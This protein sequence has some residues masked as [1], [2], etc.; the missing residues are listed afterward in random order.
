MST[1]L[2]NPKDERSFEKKIQTKAINTQKNIYSA[3][4]NFE[5]FCKEKYD[6]SMDETIAEYQIVDIDI[7]YL[8]L[9]EWINWNS[10]KGIYPNSIPT[11]FSYLKK[12]FRHFKIKIT[13]EDIAE[14]LSFP[15]IIDEEKHPLT[16]DEIKKIFNVSN[17][18]NSLKILAQISSGLRRGEMLRLRKKDLDVTQDRIMV[19]VPASITKTKKSRVTFFSKE[20]SAL[21]LTRLEVL[22]DDDRVFSKGFSTTNVS[23]HYQMI[24]L[25][26]LKRA[27]LD[28][29][30]ESGRHKITTHSFRAYFITK[31]SRHD[32]NL[33][34]L[35]AGQDQ[36]R[37]LLMYDRLTS[38]EKLE[39]YIEFESDLLIY[40]TKDFQK[41]IQ[42]K[43]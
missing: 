31:I 4:R 14:Q 25:E 34:K 6:K 29:K 33:A 12:Y 9:Q 19:N 27:N 39:K 1:F 37:D 8:S 16:K 22:N 2:S 28:Q 7:V 41:Y 36:S 38:S 3:I 17:R 26:Y 15:H 32:P 40:D 21:L 11:I 23:N 10:H 5:R 35:F 20:V 43:K 42:C 30:Y 13:K 18:N 24:L